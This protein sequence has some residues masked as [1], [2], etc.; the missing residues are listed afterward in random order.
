[1]P[2]LEPMSNGAARGGRRGRAAHV[3]SSLAEINVVPLVDVMLVLLIIFMVAAP[4]MQ[5]GLPVQLPQ[6]RQSRATQAPVTITVP[7]SFRRD[8]RVEIGDDLVPLDVL[9]E[10]V[11]Q[12]LDA[13]GQQSVMLASD[14]GIPM[15]EIISVWDR[16]EA[17]GVHTVNVQTQPATGR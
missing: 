2:K 11:K 12:A 4:T 13:R 10:R 3:S 5:Q 8:H 16:L 17:G 6:S 9:A 1:M 7:L 14:A 15:G